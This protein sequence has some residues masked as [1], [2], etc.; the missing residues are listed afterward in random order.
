MFNLRNVQTG[1]TLDNCSAEQ[2][3][4]YLNENG[5]TA[6]DESLRDEFTAIF[7]NPEWADRILV[8]YT[9]SDEPEEAF[10]ELKE[11]L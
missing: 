2:T 6:E 5:A 8:E 3:A 4:E 1:E 10:D 7:E 11:L 9:G